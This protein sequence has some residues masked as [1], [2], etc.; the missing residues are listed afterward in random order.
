VHGCAYVTLCNGSIRS[1]EYIDTEAVRE[2]ITVKHVNTTRLIRSSPNAPGLHLLV[3]P[4][5]VASLLC[6]QV[7]FYNSELKLSPTKQMK[8]SRTGVHRL[9][10]LKLDL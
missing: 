9:S 7:E 5:V 1:L 10:L 2:N 8:I 4:L 3:Q 6:F